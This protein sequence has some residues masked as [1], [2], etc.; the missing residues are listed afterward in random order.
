MTS[1]PLAHIDSRFFP[2][3]LLKTNTDHF[4][5]P[6]DLFPCRELN[7]CCDIYLP[8]GHHF[9]WGGI[10]MLLSTVG[11]HLCVCARVRADLFYW[12]TSCYRTSLMPLYL[13]I[14]SV[15]HKCLLLIII[16]LTVSVTMQHSCQER[17]CQ[18]PSGTG[19]GGNEE[20]PM[21]EGK[22]R[23]AQWD[24]V[25][26]KGK[27][28]GPR[29]KCPVGQEGKMMREPVGKRKGEGILVVGPNIISL[30]MTAQPSRDRPVTSNTEHSFAMTDDTQ[31]W[32]LICNDTQHW[33]LTCNDTQHWTLTC[34]HTQH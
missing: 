21:G 30:I 18:G 20:G 19:P 29:G 31:H 15:H 12:G 8:R 27:G 7:L 32:T 22:P 1:L 16:I 3:Y 17:D 34:N 5:W 26:G 6:S 2:V 24:W 4:S 11:V 23:G 25:R 10:A 13:W 14:V 9:G 33:T 28:E